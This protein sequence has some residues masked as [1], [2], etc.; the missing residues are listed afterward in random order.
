MGLMSPREEGGKFWNDC[1]RDDFRLTFDWP[2]GWNP[3]PCMVTPQLS[4]CWVRL[5]FGSNSV[6]TLIPIMTVS[7]PGLYRWTDVIMVIVVCW[8][9][10][11]SKAFRITDL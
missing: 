1:K 8:F 4:Y 6:S 3:K 7:P 10:L 9:E 2:R 5:L 11:K